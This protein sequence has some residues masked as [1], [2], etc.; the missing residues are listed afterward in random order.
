MANIVTEN[1]AIGLPVVGGAAGL[2]QVFYHWPMLGILV[3]CLGLGSAWAQESNEVAWPEGTS[4]GGSV[5]LSPPDVSARDFT[6]P[7][8]LLLSVVSALTLLARNG[9]R[10]TVV[11]QV[12]GASLKEVADRIREAVEGNRDG[13]LHAELLAELKRRRGNTDPGA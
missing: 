2:P 13:Q 8:G 9:L 4:S 3:G 5:S 6:F 11:H 1:V 7:V 10:V 12:D